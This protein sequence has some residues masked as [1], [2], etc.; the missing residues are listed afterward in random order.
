M[1][2]PMDEG[3]TLQRKSGGGVGWSSVHV[4]VGQVQVVVLLVV[5]IINDNAYIKPIYTRVTTKLTSSL[6]RHYVTV[7]L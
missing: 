4:R 2:I 1:V 5:V 7:V 3:S 6:H